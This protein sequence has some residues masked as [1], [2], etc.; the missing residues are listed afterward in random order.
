MTA[1]TA[2]RVTL[3]VSAGTLLSRQRT[4]GK[5][6]ADDSLSPRRKILREVGQSP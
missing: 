4:Q 6:F 1:D 2:A 5:I 3:A